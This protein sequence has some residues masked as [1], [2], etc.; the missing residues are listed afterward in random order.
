MQLKTYNDLQKDIVGNLWKIPNDV[1]L[2]VGIPRSGILA[3]SF[4][5]IGLRAL[6]K[7]G[8]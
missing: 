1:D 5:E 2:I 3:A 7:V 4:I 6:N 8:Q